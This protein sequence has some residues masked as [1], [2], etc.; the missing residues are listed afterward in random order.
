MGRYMDFGG[1]IQM[2]FSQFIGMTPGWSVAEIAV[3]PV[4]DRS[5]VPNM[6]LVPQFGTGPR[7]G[8]TSHLCHA[9]FVSF[10]GEK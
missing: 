9:S 7:T 4:R 6:G 5:P 2:T 8:P 1:G 10:L 3:G